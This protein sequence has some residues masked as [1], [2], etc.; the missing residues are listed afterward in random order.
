M[1]KWLSSLRD[2]LHSNRE[3][4]DMEFTPWESI[5]NYVVA[6][7]RSSRTWVSDHSDLDR[8]SDPGLSFFESGRYLCEYRNEYDVVYN[9]EVTPMEVLEDGVI[10]R[11][12]GASE[13]DLQD[14]PVSCYLAEDPSF[15]DEGH[16]L[17]HSK[18]DEEGTFDFAF[19]ALPIVEE[20]VIAEDR[21]TEAQLELIRSLSFCLV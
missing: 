17:C 11:D 7:D 3:M 13:D 10:A 21:C 16:Y 2:E 14:S 9:V 5:D 15:F 20:N 18:Y 1:L 4:L 6:D 19:E 8:S 12:I